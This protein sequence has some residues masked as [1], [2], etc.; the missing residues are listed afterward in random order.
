MV[1]LYL[2]LKAPSGQKSYVPTVL[3]N[4]GPRIYP[5]AEEA[6]THSLRA[7]RRRERIAQLMAGKLPALYERYG[8]LKEAATQV[9]KAEMVISRVANFLGASERDAAAI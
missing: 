3:D 6:Q 9:A 2:K 7:L 1:K 5:R 8:R 4:R